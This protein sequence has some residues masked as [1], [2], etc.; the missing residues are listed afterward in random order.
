MPWT[1]LQAAGSLAL[2]SATGRR[3][4]SPDPAGPHRPKSPHTFDGRNRSPHRSARANRR[5]H[6]PCPAT[7]TLPWAY[8]AAFRPPGSARSAVPAW[9]M[10]C[11]VP[12]RAHPTDASPPQIPAGR[13]MAGTDL[14]I[15]PRGRS[16]GG[17]AHA[18]P[19]GL[20]H[21]PIPPLSARLDP[22]GVRSLPGKWTAMPRE[23]HFR[24]R[25]RY[26]NR[27]PE[28]QR[29][30][31]PKNAGQAGGPGF[32]PAGRDRGQ[33][34]SRLREMLLE[35]ALAESCACPVIV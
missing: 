20:C 5:R 26:R 18:R 27:R 21:G 1:R 4:A 12:D 13:S 33:I 14:R 11:Q 9:R 23:R 3:T 35:P 28:G 15:G 29:A 17:S 32:F 7:R 34:R 31:N 16:G 30:W 22:H 25:Y 24:Y 10:D 8:P 2:P 6:G 19:Q